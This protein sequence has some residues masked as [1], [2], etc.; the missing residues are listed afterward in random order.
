MVT[1]EF[2]LA[3]PVIVSPA[4]TVLL[5]GSATVGFAAGEADATVNGDGEAIDPPTG[6]VDGLGEA[7]LP[8]TGD[9]EGEGDDDSRAGEAEGEGEVVP[10]PAAIIVMVAGFLAIM[11]F[12][13]SLVPAALVFGPKVIA[14]LPAAFASNLSVAM[15]P[16]PWGG[17]AGC[18]PK[19][20]VADP[21][22]LLI[23][24]LANSTGKSVEG[25]KLA[26]VSFSLS[27][28][29]SSSVPERTLVEV[30]TSTVTSKLSPTKIVLAGFL[31]LMVVAGAAFSRRSCCW[32]IK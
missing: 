14:A 30:S 27:K 3:V 5:V 22:V 25:E 4:L 21:A 29:I 11:T 9:A 28:L 2:G 1:F 13:A 32:R 26:S 20:I 8:V 15:V 19:L 31:I 16:F 23:W 24:A 7:E 6:A 12:V 18:A 10:P 17:L